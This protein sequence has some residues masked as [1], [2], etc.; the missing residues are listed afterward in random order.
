MD[1]FQNTI[2]RIRTRN[3]YR[4]INDKW[5]YTHYKDNLFKFLDYADKKIVSS[6]LTIKGE[7]LDEMHTL[8]D[9]LKPSF[10]YQPE[11]YKIYNIY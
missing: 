11:I 3:K 10:A 4:Y 8:I 2:D 9:K 1:R 7:S 6:H 5:N